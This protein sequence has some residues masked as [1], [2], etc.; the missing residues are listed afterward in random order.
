M[1]AIEPSVSQEIKAFARHRKVDCL[2]HF[3]RIENLP[4]ILEH[5]LLDTVDL[6]IKDISAKTNDWHRRDNLP[7]AICCSISFPNYKLFY[8]LR[9]EQPNSKWV[10][11]R[12]KPEVLWT[13][14]CV[15][16][17]TNAANRSVAQLNM[18]HLDNRKTRS[19]FEEMYK[20]K[21]DQYY[22]KSMLI[23]DWYPT[24]PQAEILVL[25]PIGSDLLTEVVYEKETSELQKLKNSYQGLF[26]FAESEFY[27]V[28]RPDFRNYGNK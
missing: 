20:D 22:R 21:V 25:D 18:E 9:E 11:I 16:C 15:F 3:T 28:E 10:V 14:D 2:V 7:N 12:M 17:V 24:D 6:A 8:R 4:T 19:A 23:P 26:N 27:F 13:K 5:G 1:N